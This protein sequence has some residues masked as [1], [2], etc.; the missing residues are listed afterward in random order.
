MLS[1]VNTFPETSKIT[2]LLTDII[3]PLTDMRWWISTGLAVI[4][5][6]LLVDGRASNIG[7]T[8]SFLTAPL[9][10]EDDDEAMDTGVPAINGK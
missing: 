10:E 6:D 2:S 3:L 5:V 4:V 8:F 1:V 9:V 7:V